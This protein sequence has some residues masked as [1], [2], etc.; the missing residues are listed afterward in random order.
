[1]KAAVAKK[2]VAALRSGKYKR[3][4]GALCKSKTETGKQTYCCLGVLTELYPKKLSKE[5]REGYWAYGDTGSPGFPPQEVLDW[6]GFFYQNPFK[7][8]DDALTTLNDVKDWSFNRMAD[9]IEK[10]YKGIK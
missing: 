1:M 10:H 9:Y 5:Y 6:A 2:W 7:P 8:G 4:K 3:G